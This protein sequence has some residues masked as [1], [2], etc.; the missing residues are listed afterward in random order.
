MKREKRPDF[1]DS[2]SIPRSSEQGTQSTG[3]T[4][5]EGADLRVLRRLLDGPD[6]AK[7]WGNLSPIWTPE[8]QC[9]WLCKEYAVAF[10][11]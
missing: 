6:L 10:R 2:V 9:L 7:M 1:D 4:R 8:G 11:N 3:A 5:V